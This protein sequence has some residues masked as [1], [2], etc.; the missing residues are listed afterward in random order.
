MPGKRV[1]ATVKDVPAD[2]FIKAYAAHLKRT[3]TIQLPEWVGYVKTAPYKELAPYDEDWFYIRAAAIARRLYIRRGT[4][5]GAFTK[6]FG[7][8]SSRGVKSSRFARASPG[9]IR[10]VIQQLEAI[11]VVQKVPKGG[12]Q[13]TRTGRAELDRIASAIVNK[14]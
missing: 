11:K 13:L 7:G 5:V 10:S 2:V 12:R 6:V 9:V 1:S 4:G 3:G 8:S 14:Q